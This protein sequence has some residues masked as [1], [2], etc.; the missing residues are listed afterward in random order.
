MIRVSEEAQAL[1]RRL[2][3]NEGAP[4]GGVRITAAGEE[5]GG[6]AFELQATESPERGD[7]VLETGGVR[8]FLDRQ[9]A[10]ALD[11]AELAVEDGDLA[12]AVPEAAG[13]T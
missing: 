13:C 5:D 7:V 4:G 12:L 2:L 6:S 8:L 1:I 9:A 3:T 10:D 11:D